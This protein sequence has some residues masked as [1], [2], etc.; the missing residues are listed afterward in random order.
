MRSHSLFV[1]AAGAVELLPRQVRA[2]RAIVASTTATLVALASHLAAGGAPPPLLLI[3]TVCALSWLPGMLLIGRRPSLIGQGA[4]VLLAEAAL[5][6]VFAL[7][8]GPAG[9][10]LVPRASAAMA[11]MPGMA[12]PAAD[13]LMSMAVPTGWMWVAHGIAGVLT[14]LAWNRGEHAFWALVRFGRRVR[15]AVLPDLHVAEPAPARRSQPAVWAPMCSA[16]HLHRVLEASPRRGP[17]LAP[18]F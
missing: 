6:A 1:V 14:V 8:A 13:P 18:Q 5:H 3:V 16:P 4:T 10:A 15:L 11:A 7:A 2:V 9:A 12:P 17:P